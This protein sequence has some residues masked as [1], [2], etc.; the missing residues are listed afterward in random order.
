MKY[1][2]E[3]ENIISSASGTEHVHSE[4]SREKVKAAAE[5]GEDVSADFVGMFGKKIT[6]LPGLRIFFF[7]AGEMVEMNRDKHFGVLVM[8]IAQFK[9]VNEFCGRKVGDALLSYIS[10]LFRAYED[11]RPLTISGHARA[12]VFLMCTQFES[13]DEII[14]IA[15]DLYE[16]ITSYNTPFKV[17]PSFGIYANSE[18][19]QSVSYMKDCATIALSGIKGKF[20]KKYAIYNEEMRK[21]ILKEKKIENDLVIAFEKQE[22]KV[23]IQ[24]KTDMR[25]GEILG[26]EAL[27]RWNHSKLGIIPPID[28]IPVAENDGLIIKLDF[29]VWEQVFAY[30]RSRK[31]N[32]KKLYNISI[33]ISRIH[34]YDDEM[35]DKLIS[36]SKT[37]DIPPEYVTLELTESA[38]TA[39]DNKIYENMQLLRE[40]GFPISMDDFGTGL[41]SMQML[42]KQPLNEIKIDRSFIVGMDNPKG[43]IVLEN[44]IRMLNEIDMPIIAEGVETESQKEA[45]IEYGCSNSQGYLFY[46]PMPIEE[47]DDLIN[48]N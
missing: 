10:D 31:R 9:A 33:N 22:F 32:N 26:G 1:Q 21:R 27:V 7:Q 28:F 23:Y 39:D 15:E 47:F 43:R 2:K 34:M 25:T 13:P 36:L 46:K 20:Y 19:I 48:N 40:Y 8:D 42:T 30:L 24:P 44:I 45:L 38:F 16:R 35:C 5:K 6:D 12:D 18:T 17:L 3:V 4:Y 14:S 41:S 37:Y 29:W 11:T